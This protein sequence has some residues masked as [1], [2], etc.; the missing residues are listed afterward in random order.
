MEEIKR[1]RPVMLCILDGW[2]HRDSKENNAIETGNTPNW[3]ELVKTC[4]NTLIATSG[5]DV[6][7]PAGQMGNS[8]V[9]HMNI[10]AG[11]VVMQDLP[12]IDQSF[13]DGSLAKRPDVF[14]LI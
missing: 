1:P 8:E 4:P 11:R 6:G 5:L 13:A 14:D 2:G 12:K 7:L 3:H 10:G 9:G